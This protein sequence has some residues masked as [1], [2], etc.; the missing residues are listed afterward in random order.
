M[1]TEELDD[2]DFDDMDM[3]NNDSEPE[4]TTESA[5]CPDVRRRLEDRLEE[6]RLKRQLSDYDFDMDD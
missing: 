3:E 5:T 2:T 1:G 6:Q 4:S